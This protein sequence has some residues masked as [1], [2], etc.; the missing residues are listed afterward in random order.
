MNTAEVD[1]NAP[2]IELKIPSKEAEAELPAMADTPK[3]LM[4]G[5]TCRFA[6]GNR[7]LE[8]EEGIPKRMIFLNIFLYS[9]GET[10]P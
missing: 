7:R 6:M 3:E 8:I 4:A 9:A 2:G 5:T 10:F 1:E